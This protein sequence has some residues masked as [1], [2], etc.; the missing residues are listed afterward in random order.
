M[1]LTDK[2]DL[3]LRVLMVLAARQDRCTAADLAD[4]LDA[5]LNH[6]V[7]VVQ[8]LQQHAWVRTTRGRSGGIDLTADPN[9]LTAGDVVRRIESG[10]DLVECF[11]DSGRCPLERGCGL[12]GLIADARSAFLESLDSATLA[13]LTGATERVLLRIT[14]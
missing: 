13:E 3:A 10:F 7:K 2:T 11:R 1:R 8:A 9:T 14:A 6:V 4:W 12:A 5:P